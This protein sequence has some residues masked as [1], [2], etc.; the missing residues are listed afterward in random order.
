MQLY[1]EE[2][3]VGFGKISL[4]HT[5]LLIVTSKPTCIVATMKKKHTT[6]AS[7]EVVSLW[8][9]G[10]GVIISARRGQKVWFRWES[11]HT[12]LL[13]IWDD[14]DPNSAPNGHSPSR[15]L[16]RLQLPAQWLVNALLCTTQCQLT[17]VERFLNSCFQ[18]TFLVGSIISTIWRREKM[19][20]YKSS[21]IEALNRHFFRKRGEDVSLMLRL[22]K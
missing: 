15:S 20:Q 10:C 14:S 12:F 11:A 1:F 18:G 8:Y 22:G 4:Q 2:Y 13:C 7:P 17:L 19:G 16:G 3:S 21:S 5:I 9:L 6:K